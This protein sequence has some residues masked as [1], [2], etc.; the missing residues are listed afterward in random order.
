MGKI[1]EK[2]VLV[3]SSDY[4]YSSLQTSKNREVVSAIFC[5]YRVNGYNLKTFRSKL[6]NKMRRWYEGEASLKEVTEFTAG[7]K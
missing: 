2:L 3:H 4:T 5:E 7:R 6:G 1:C